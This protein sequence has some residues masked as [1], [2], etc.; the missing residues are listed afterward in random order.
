MP[1]GADPELF[2]PAGADPRVVRERHGLGSRLTIGWTGILREWHGVELLLDALP[3]VPD[4]CLLIVGDG[5]ARAA[6]EARAGAPAGLQDRVVITGRVPHEA[7]RDHV[8]AMD[9][10]VVADE[11][12]G[13]ASPMKLVEYMAMARA[14]VAPRLDNIRDLVDDDVDGLLFAQGDAAA[15]GAVF[16]RLAGDSALRERLGRAARR[17]VETTRNW[18]QNAIGVLGLVASRVPR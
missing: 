9:I 15:L 18:R 5:P 4:A 6:L 7:M 10:A 16:R 12:T 13:I 1:N 3:L 11:R 2:D 14:V 8:A 17:K